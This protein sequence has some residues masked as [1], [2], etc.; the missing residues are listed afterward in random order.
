MFKVD[1]P[2][3]DSFFSGTGDMFAALTVARFREAVVAANLD[4]AASWLS[5]DDVETLDLPLTKAVEKVLASMQQVLEKTKKA[6]DA[7]LDREALRLNNPDTNEKSKRLRKV[8]AAEVR[9]VRNVA[10]LMHPKVKRT[11]HA[12]DI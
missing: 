6:M 4:E 12:V 5:G 10:D 9:L 3:I 7:E 1:I 11:A 8:K 2:K